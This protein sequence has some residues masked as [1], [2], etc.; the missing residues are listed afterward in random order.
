MKSTEKQL[1]VRQI[2]DGIVLT[3]T[4]PTETTITTR[5]T[6]SV[7]IG[8]KVLDMP[9]TTI[10]KTQ[11]IRVKSWTEERTITVPMYTVKKKHT[12]KA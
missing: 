4:T 2:P 6:E 8:D 1:T 11:K 10:Q 7:K 5:K 9:V 12:K 3:E